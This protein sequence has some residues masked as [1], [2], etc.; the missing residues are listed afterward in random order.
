M[1]KC[2]HLISHID[3]VK[4]W[5]YCQSCGKKGQYIEIS[6]GVDNEGMEAVSSLPCPLKLFM[7]FIS[8]LEDSSASDLPLSDPFKTGYLKGLE[9]YKH[10]TFASRPMVLKKGFFKKL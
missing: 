2:Q 4:H 1:T 6:Y 10:C 9:S 8:T 7:P 3:E 5:Y